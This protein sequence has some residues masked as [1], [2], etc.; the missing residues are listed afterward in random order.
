MLEYISEHTIVGYV[1]GALVL[2]VGFA[3]TILKLYKPLQDLNIGITK[4]TTIMQFI[5]GEQKDLKNRVAMHGKAL[6]NITNQL[7]EY[8]VKIEQFEQFEK[9][10]REHEHHQT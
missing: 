6:D 1:L 7:T 8:R 10:V 9:E 3:A 2:I 4:L 5:L